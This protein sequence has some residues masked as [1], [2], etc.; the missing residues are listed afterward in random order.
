ML[1]GCTTIGTDG[2]IAAPQTC[3][4]FTFY[5]SEDFEGG[6]QD[7]PASVYVWPDGQ[8]TINVEWMETTRLN[9]CSVPI[10]AMKGFLDL[11][12]CASYIF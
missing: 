6:G 9:G 10:S 5:L 3:A 8:R 2:M 7:V 11:P 4:T 12:Q 1:V